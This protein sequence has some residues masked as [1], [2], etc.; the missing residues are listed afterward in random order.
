MELCI[1]PPF[2]FCY[3]P[4]VFVCWEEEAA[5]I[6]INQGDAIARSVPGIHCHGEEDLGGCS[7]CGAFLEHGQQQ[8]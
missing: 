6:S 8:R 4:V 5:S 1:Q 3:R 7:V 2:I